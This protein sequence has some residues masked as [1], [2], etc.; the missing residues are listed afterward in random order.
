MSSPRDPGRDLSLER[1][2][3]RDGRRPVPLNDAAMVSETLGPHAIQ[4][5]YRTAYEALIDAVFAGPGA[6]EWLFALRRAVTA[7]IAGKS[8]IAQVKP[9]AIRQPEPGESRG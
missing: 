9:D 7:L 8:E 1:L 6:V 2:G 5:D 3:D 4:K